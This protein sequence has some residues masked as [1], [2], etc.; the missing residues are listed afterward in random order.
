MPP[1]PPNARTSFEHAKKQCLALAITMR[2]TLL[3]RREHV[4][5]KLEM[6]LNGPHAHLFV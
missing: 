1:S 5:Y 6:Q 4:I 2:G 3:Q